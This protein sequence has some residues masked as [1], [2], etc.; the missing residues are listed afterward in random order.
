[1]QRQREELRAAG[2]FSKMRE[3][4]DIKQEQGEA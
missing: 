4:C 1:M 3:I 2:V